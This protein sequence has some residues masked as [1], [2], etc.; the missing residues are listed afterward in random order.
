MILVSNLNEEQ[1]V[2]LG[3]RYAD[4]LDNAIRE[5]YRAVPQAKV[6]ILPAGGVIVPMKRDMSFN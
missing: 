4:S 3:F 2:R 1:V 6:N 5:L